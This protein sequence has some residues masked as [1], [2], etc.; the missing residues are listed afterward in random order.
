M[1]ESGSS[2]LLP[3]GTLWWRE[4]LRFY[5]QRSRVIG[6][7][8]SPLV[9]WLLIGSG[10]GTSF[11]AP[12]TAD[13]SS[14]GIL[15]SGQ[16]GGIGYL[17]YFFPGTLVLILLFTSIFCMMS[18][19]EDRREGFLLSVLVAPISR[20][21]LVLGK[22]LGGTTLAVLQAIVFLLLAPVVGISLY[23]LQI[24]FLVAILFLIA[25]GLTGLGFVVAWR[26]DS[27]QG[28]HAIVNLFLIP[29]WLLSGALFPASGAFGW[30]RWIMKA[31]PLTY[32]TAA[33]RQVL[34][35]PVQ[36][37]EGGV[38]SLALSLGVTA[39]FGVF[40]IGIAFRV[41]RQRAI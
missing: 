2:F 3:L 25:L 36:A 17:E 34:Y 30:V 37:A 18:V 4:L 21:T 29:M 15:A 35:L 16:A 41:A 5:R 32:G 19:I 11:R 24:L 27:V 13:A 8:G 40:M 7:V 14:R 26:M 38:S 31:N 20:S 6:V 1:E 28:F 12:S 22:V 10:L 9:F 33:L 39:L 23:P